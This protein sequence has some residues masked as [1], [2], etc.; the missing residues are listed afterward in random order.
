MFFG[1]L[2]AAFT[3]I[4]RALRPGGRLCLLTWQPPASNEWIREIAG[5]LTAGRGLPLPPPD[6]PGPFALSN[7]GR[8]HALLSAAGYTGVHVDPSDG[9]AWAGRDADDAYR[10]LLGLMGWML[11]GLDDHSRGQALGA[12]R[13]SLTAHDTGSG[14]IYQSAIWTI[15]TIRP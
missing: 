4:A 7:P 10:F 2:V 8:I 1:D 5:A 13:T 12:L 6:A 9:G 11:Q 15:R 14:V 3:N